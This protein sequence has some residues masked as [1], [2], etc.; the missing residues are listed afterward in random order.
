M[1]RNSAIVAHYK[2]TPVD[3]PLSFYEQ[4]E[5]ASKLAEE[6]RVMTRPKRV[7]GVDM[8]KFPGAQRCKYCGSSKVT[9]STLALKCILCNKIT[10][11]WP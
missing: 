3:T 2:N 11:R 4:I 7:V 1:G 8:R 9:R 6:I 10:W 5:N